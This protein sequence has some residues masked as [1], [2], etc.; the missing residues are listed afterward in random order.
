[1]DK[2][3]FYYTYKIFL[4]FGILAI[5][6]T[7]LTVLDNFWMQLL[8]AG[9]L[10]FVFTQ[11]GFI[12]HDAG[13]REIFNSPR[14]NEILGLICTL[15]VGVSYSWWTDTHNQHHRKPNQ[16]DLDPAIDF[17]A[18]VFTE[19]QALSKKGFLKFI[20]KYQAY[21]FFPLM[22]LY[23]FSIWLNSTKFLYQNKVRYSLAE[24]VFVVTHY[25]LYFGL[26]FSLLGVS[27]GLLFVIVHYL[28]FGLYGGSVFASNHKGMPIVEKDEP[29]D[30]LY[31]QSLTSRNVKSHPLTDFWYG[32]LNYQIEHHLFPSMARNKLRD[33]QKI[34]RPFFQAHSI[35]Y[36]ETSAIR[37]YWEILEYFHEVSAPLRLKETE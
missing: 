12:G 36:Y 24:P 27:K 14:N 35:P 3:P 28:L 29:L 9:Y 25:V 11:I 23:P 10:G 8:V 4:T 20:V 21:F 7:F 22:S 6:V 31:Q 2:Q 33:A 19:E 30:F 32:G 5:G 34:V 37:S 13:H 17:P 16:V 1:L 15:L 18:P 26:L